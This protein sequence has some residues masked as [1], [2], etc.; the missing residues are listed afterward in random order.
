MGVAPAGTQKAGTGHHHLLVDTELKSSDV[1]IPNDA[2][3]LHLGNG[4]TEIEVTLRPGRHRL[5]LVLGDHDHVVHR[6]PV[7]SA[8]ITITVREQD[9]TGLQ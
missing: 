6:P 4:Q 9:T 5:Q 1:P 8:P 3:H 2:Q 7:T